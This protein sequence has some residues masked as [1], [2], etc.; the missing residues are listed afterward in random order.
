VAE[1]QTHAD[2]T[3]D[4]HGSVNVDDLLELAQRI[5]DG[6]AGCEPYKKCLAAKAAIVPD[7]VI[8][9][10]LYGFC[11]RR[12]ALSVKRMDGGEITFAEEQETAR[13]YAELLLNDDA[14]T[15]LENEKLFLALAADI[16]RII[17]SGIDPDFL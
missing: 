17:D 10:K 1:D 12:L 13:L 2:D 11:R 3:A 6:L 7:E 4:N 8:S 15:Y 16:H 5:A 9:S 14:R